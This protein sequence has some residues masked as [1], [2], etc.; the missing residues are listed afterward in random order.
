MKKV[1]D[2]EVVVQPWNN[3]IHFVSLATDISLQFCFDSSCSPSQF[4]GFQDDQIWSASQKTGFPVQ[5]MGKQIRTHLLF[6]WIGSRMDLIPGID[7]SSEG[8][9]RV[10]AC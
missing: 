1:F 3:G 7:G 5:P 8:V 2:A 6:N 9:P 10:L 4:L